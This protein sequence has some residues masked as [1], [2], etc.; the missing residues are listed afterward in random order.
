MFCNGERHCGNSAFEKQGKNL[1]VKT[2][3]AK[4]RYFKCGIIDFVE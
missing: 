3:F 4:I 2:R 1:V